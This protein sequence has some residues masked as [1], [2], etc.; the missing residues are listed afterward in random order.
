MSS[1]LSIFALLLLP[2]LSLA[3]SALAPESPVT[4]SQQPK[5]G[6]LGALAR[7]VPCNLTH[8][9][10]GSPITQAVEIIDVQKDGA[11]YQKGLRSGDLLISI[12]GHPVAPC[13]EIKTQ[14]MET[15]EQGIIKLE[16]MRGQELIEIS[17][18]LSAYQANAA[19]AASARAL[20]KAAELFDKDQ[21]TRPVSLNEDHRAKV[22]EYAGKIKQ[23]LSQAP[24]DTDARAIIRNMQNI[25]NVFRDSNKQSQGWMSGKAGEA[26][27]QFK[28]GPYILILKGMNNMLRLE[29]YNQ[30][31]ALI[32]AGSMDSPAQRQ[33]VPADVLH[34]LQ[35]L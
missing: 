22:A 21:T 5:A 31:G 29:V 24:D 27:I 10:T 34:V 30:A 33:A 8:P 11:S 2:T 18:K 20:K 3:A 13:A 19:S 1:P 4:A 6:G 7:D 9:V 17:G 14:L 16:L 25:R 32:F 28:K 15:T 35:S 12:N 23:E 26:T